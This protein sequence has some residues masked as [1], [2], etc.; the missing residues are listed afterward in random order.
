[1][2][3]MPR[4]KIKSKQAVLTLSQLHVKLAGKLLDKK[5]A[6]IEPGHLGY[7]E[8]TIDRIFAVMD[9][10]DAA[11]AADRIKSGYGLRVV[12]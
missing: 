2:T 9:E 3:A 11:S 12:K 5:R 7:P 6:A 1:M 8:D 4:A 10:H